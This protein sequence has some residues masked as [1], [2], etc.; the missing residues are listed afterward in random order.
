[1]DNRPDTTSD[2][3]VSSD[4]FGSCHR[5]PTLP[6]K[7]SET[8]EEPPSVKV[9]K[10]PVTLEVK[11]TVKAKSATSIVKPTVKVKSARK[12]KPTLKVNRQFNQTAIQ[13]VKRTVKPRRDT[14]NV[15]KRKAESAMESDTWE[16][17]ALQ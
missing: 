5:Y 15:P 11:L 14:E 7:P 1:M 9:Q 8:L 3:Q 17:F 16:P 4:I 12:V 2:K 13:T 6:S 10:Q